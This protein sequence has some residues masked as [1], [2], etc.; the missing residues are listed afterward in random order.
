MNL[1]ELQ[2]KLDK[3]GVPRN[4]YILGGLPLP[5]G[6]F[7]P[8]VLEMRQVEGHNQW[9]YY[10]MDERGGKSDF[11]FFDNELDAYQYMY[12]KVTNKWKSYSTEYNLISQGTVSERVKQ[13]LYEIHHALEEGNDHVYRYECRSIPFIDNIQKLDAYVRKL[14]ELNGNK[15][16]TIISHKNTEEKYYE[17]S[18]DGVKI[19]LDE[20]N[21][22][23]IIDGAIDGN[24]L[25]K[26]SSYDLKEK[27][28]EEKEV[29]YTGKL[30]FLEELDNEADACT[31][32]YYYL[33]N[34][35]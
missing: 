31:V 1:L 13:L 34:K 8:S 28:R 30:S 23:W 32:F 2:R 18:F 5:H 20:M 4:F 10:A 7:E 6:F 15:Y 21:G 35:Y 11:H 25:L 14:I 29:E 3:A 17:L 9:V 33:R 24:W 22:K 26:E 19:T 16:C 27:K 12:N